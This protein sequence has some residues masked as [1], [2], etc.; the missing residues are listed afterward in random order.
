MKLI[1]KLQYKFLAGLSH[2]EWHESNC[3]NDAAQGFESILSWDLELRRT[4]EAL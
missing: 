1:N 4:A 3:M 2:D